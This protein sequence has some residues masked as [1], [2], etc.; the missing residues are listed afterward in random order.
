M[1]S[2]LPPCAST[3]RV[4]N[5]GT[6]ELRLSDALACDVHERDG[7]FLGL[8]E[9]RCDGVSLRGATPPMLPAIRTPD[10]VELVRPRLVRTVVQPDSIDLELAWQR[11]D[12]ATMDWMLH[13][14]RPVRRV[15]DWSQPERQAEETLLTIELRPVERRCDD[16]MLRG[17]SYRYRYQS[18]AYPIF[19]LLDQGSWEPGG[20]AAGNT[21]FLRNAFSP[22]IR[23]FGGEDDF[24][25]TEWYL[26]SAANPQ[27]FQFLPFQTEFSGF[28]FTS[29]PAGTLVS[30]ATE[31]AHIRT[32]V[33]KPR[34]MDRV[35]HLHEH[36]GDLTGR[37][38]TVPVEVLFLPDV[39]DAVERLNLH[40][41]FRVLVA[42]RLHA[43]LGMRREFL[44][45]YG[46]IEEWTR[47]D[48]AA[49][50][51]EALPP[52][53]DAGVRRVGLANLFQNNMNVWGV[54][55]MCCTVDYRMPSPEDESALKALCE[56]AHAAGA[57]VE[58]WANTALSSL[59][60]IFSRR[61]G[62]SDRLAPLPTAGTVTEV[63]ARSS[64]PFVRN[65]S[66]AIEADHYTP[67]FAV[68]NLRDDDIRAYWL[69]RWGAARK[70]MG[71]DGIFLDSSFN[72]SSDKF[73]WVRNPD[74][75]ERSG[76]T[77][78][79]TQLLGKTRPA[80]LSTGMVLSQYRAH[81]DLMVAMQRL[82]YEYCGEDLG[83]FGIHRHGPGAVQRLGSL[84]LWSD[85]I[86]WFDRAAL[87]KAGADPEDVFF[88]G[89]AY[90]MVWGLS[91]DFRKRALSLRQEGLR[92]DDDRPTEKELSLLRTYAAV[93]PDMRGR[94]ILETERG[95]LYTAGAQQVL[96]A[97]AS[98]TLEPP[99]D[100]RVVDLT[101][102][103]TMESRPLR[104]ETRHVYRWC[105]PGGQPET[106]HSLAAGGCWPPGA[107][108]L[109]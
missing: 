19:C 41:A 38:D 5:V 108:Q 83:V 75:G 22:S 20:S 1:S 62:T 81:L 100:A 91:W 6:T 40:E 56:R 4:S 107:I 88:R 92:G 101:T 106:G 16:R 85:C 36:C 67:V 28:T 78:D 73:H 46:M 77:A 23:T 42:E 32:L 76:G 31:V 17:F 30:W 64:A 63:L 59:T 37:F 25:S 24:Y 49:Y 74:V 103:E 51:R 14:V 86:A 3:P 11:R 96:W 13:T 57:K 53:L 97:F 50:A 95:V 82:G 21:L 68:L 93:E 71:L 15:G 104:A 69:E 48:I 52:L 66:H 8:G 65:P 33:E 89:L 43:Q 61:N 2:P 12:T 87:R 72:L 79:Q 35:L 99:P 7:E 80:R 27:I 98:F 18:S 102:R 26:P 47:A 94:H 84:P 10:G 34:G 58:L 70:D 55:N 109:C 60:E 9:I 54:G 45:T 44:T 105:Q 29:G 39:L 90:R